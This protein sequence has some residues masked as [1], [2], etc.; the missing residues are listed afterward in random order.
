MMSH[1]A[2]APAA[3]LLVSMT[4]HT[5]KEFAVGLPPWM[6]RVA[7]AVFAINASGDP[8]MVYNYVSPASI[9]YKVELPI[10][11]YR[12]LVPDVYNFMP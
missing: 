11:L 1:K 2:K 6:W 8:G 9:W 12:G 4:G 3:K 5:A 10:L 7:S